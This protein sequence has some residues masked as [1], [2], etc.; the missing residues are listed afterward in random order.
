MTEVECGC[1]ERLMILKRNLGIIEGLLRD[2][3]EFSKR[4]AKDF[5]SI[6]RTSLFRVEDACG[7]EEQKNIRI[8]LD[9]A[10]KCIDK[11]ERYCGAF[12]IEADYETD[13]IF[14]KFC[15]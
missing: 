7:I 5:I 4:E 8:S 3:T 14:L 10:E 9:N 2:P 13:K 1:V 15:M 6:A 12:S 11:G